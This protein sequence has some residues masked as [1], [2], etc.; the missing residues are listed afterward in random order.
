ML[1]GRNLSSV[2]SMS[3]SARSSS[4]TD[5][6]FQISDLEPLLRDAGLS[7]CKEGPEVG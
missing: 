1:A 4:C 2:I 3:I 6:I 7:F 5:I